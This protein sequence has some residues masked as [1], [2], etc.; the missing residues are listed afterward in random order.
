MPRSSYKIVPIGGITLSSFS[1]TCG[2]TTKS[3]DKTIKMKIRL[4]RKKCTEPGEID[5]VIVSA[6]ELKKNLKS[7]YG[8]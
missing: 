7:Q 3:P 2:Y 5:E 6:P 1:C 4:H 8:L